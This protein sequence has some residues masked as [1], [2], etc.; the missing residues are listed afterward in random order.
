MK[1]ISLL[2]PFS[3]LQIV[4]SE[5]EFETIPVVDGKPLTTEDFKNLSKGK[6]AAIEEKGI[7]FETALSETL[8]GKGN[9]E[10]TKIL[11]EAV[12]ALKDGGNTDAYEM[13]DEMTFE[14]N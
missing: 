11:F 9:R 4:K 5:N 14:D 2:H 6:K 8:K 7:D 1:I 13:I 3:N 12:K 10:K